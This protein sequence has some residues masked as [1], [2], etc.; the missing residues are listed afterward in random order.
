M[1][2]SGKVVDSRGN[3]MPKV[4][5]YLSNGPVGWTLDT[6]TGTDRNRR[7]IFISRCAQEK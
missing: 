7:D 2:V 1:K 4:N 6:Q 3:A 5:V